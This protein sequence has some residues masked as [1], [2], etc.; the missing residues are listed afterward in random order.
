MSKRKIRPQGLFFSFPRPNPLYC[1]IYP[2]PT[3]IRYTVQSSRFPAQIRYTVQSSRYPPKSVILCNLAVPRP[4]PL[5]C[6]I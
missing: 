3:Q 5:Y 2:F 1:A 4:N 6:A